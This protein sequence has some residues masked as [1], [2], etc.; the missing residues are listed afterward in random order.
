M[1]ASRVAS[2]RE[3]RTPS[4]RGLAR[5]QVPFGRPAQP[6]AERVLQLAHLRAQVLVLL[7]E[8]CRLPHD[9]TRCA[10][11]QRQAGARERR[12]L[13]ACRPSGRRRCARAARSGRAAKLAGI[14]RSSTHSRSITARAATGKSAMTCCSARKSARAA[15][16]RLL[17]GL[18]H[19]SGLA[20]RGLVGG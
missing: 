11:P 7:R 5:R 13:R 2:S 3:T 17:V 4:N 19:A 1:I 10:P 9:G 18:R 14:C 20:F 15:A 8:R 12:R 6:D 16:R